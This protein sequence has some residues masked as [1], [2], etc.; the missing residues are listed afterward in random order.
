MTTRY[1]KRH[2]EDVARILRNEFADWSPELQ[3]PI[4]YIA[5]AL[6]NLF[7]TNNPNFDRSAFLTACGLEA[8]ERIHDGRCGEDGCSVCGLEQQLTSD[9]E[10]YA[11]HEHDKD[12][13]ECYGLEEGK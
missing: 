10:G 11:T 3:R 2:Y 13:P 12:F 4:P 7:A 8:D 9:E 6:A 1:Q 5:V